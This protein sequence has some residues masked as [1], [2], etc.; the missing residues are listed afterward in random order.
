MKHLL[1]LLVVLLALACSDKV[2]DGI[3]TK[4]QITPVLVDIHLA[5]SIFSQR[6]ALE[7]MRENFQEDL[8]LSILKKYKIDRE[9]FEKS[10]LYYG[11]HPEKYKP[12][13][14]EVL[15]RLN[16]MSAKSRATDSIQFRIRQ[17]ELRAKD[18]LQNIKLKAD[19][20][21]KDSTLQHSTKA[22]SLAKDTVGPNLI[23]PA[24]ESD[25]NIEIKAK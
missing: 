12:V 3:L 8:Y 19:S 11:K 22:D 4:K 5:E 15:N 25:K 10:V 18:S 2:P 1:I 23:K 20:L 9:V 7:G 21:A 24:P 16:E 17:A 6:Y 14:D 13:Y